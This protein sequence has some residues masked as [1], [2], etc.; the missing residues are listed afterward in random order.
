MSQDLL[1]AV[2]EGPEVDAIYEIYAGEDD[3]ADE[4]VD[5]EVYA[6]MDN[7]QVVD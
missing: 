1:E 7:I 6:E 4:G 3:D 5:P 2:A